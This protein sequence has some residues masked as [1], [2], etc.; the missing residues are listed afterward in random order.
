M[1]YNIDQMDDLLAAVRIGKYKLIVGEPDNLRVWTLPP[2]DK[3]VKRIYKGKSLL[4][5]QVPLNIP[6]TL[7]F[8]HVPVMVNS[9][10]TNVISK[11]MESNQDVTSQS[12][13]WSF[14]LTI[15]EELIPQYSDEEHYNISVD[16]SDE[17]P[18]YVDND[19]Y[20]DDYGDYHDDDDFDDADNDDDF[21]YTNETIFKDS[22]DTSY[23]YLQDNIDRRD[24]VVG[25]TQKM[26]NMNG[27][28]EGR[29]VFSIE[30]QDNS[31]S[32]ESRGHNNDKSR[33]KKNRHNKDKDQMNKKK[34]RR[35]KTNNKSRKKMSR[36][37]KDK[38]KPRKKKRPD[39]EREKRRKKKAKKKDYV[40]EE[41]NDWVTFEGLGLK[42]KKY[43]RLKKYINKNTKVALFNVRGFHCLDAK[44]RTQASG[45]SDC[46]RLSL[47]PATVWLCVKDSLTRV[48]G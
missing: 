21:H 38:N 19:D 8:D 34:R 31:V 43:H 20:N 4:F 44:T 13:R 26:V 32:R 37:N 10:D 47:I 16:S 48:T 36:R 29:A 2:E 6:T 9:I 46:D 41:A 33:K 30:R 12:T 3:D 39:K 35:N 22:N 7:D 15:R 40:T 1:V 45:S 25:D 14:Y 17:R 5:P 18:I 42:P 28:E 24:S 11:I 27:T 23:S